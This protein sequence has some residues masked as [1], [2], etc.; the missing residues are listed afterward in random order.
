[1]SVRCAQPFLPESRGL[2]A[3]VKV[4]GG[5]FLIEHSLLD[6]VNTTLDGLVQLS[7][8][9]TPRDAEIPPMEGEGSIVI[10]AIESAILLLLCNGKIGNLYVYHWVDQGW[11]FE[12]YN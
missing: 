3:K 5:L 10:V 12:W 2:S 4:S 1:M 6:L 8:M 9:L 11:G 7:F